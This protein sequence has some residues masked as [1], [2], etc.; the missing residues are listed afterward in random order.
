MISGCS[1]YRMTK[2]VVASSGFCWAFGLSECGD[3]MV[4]GGDLDAVAR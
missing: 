1:V 3:I 2:K 4:V